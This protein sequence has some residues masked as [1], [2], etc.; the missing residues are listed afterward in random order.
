MSDLRRRE[1]ISLL[2]G[3]AMWPL[4]ARTA[5]AADGNISVLMNGAAIETAPLADDVV[6]YDNCK[7]PLD[8]CGP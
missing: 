5:V 1:F 2:G 8:R 7:V 3:A 6:S 4:T